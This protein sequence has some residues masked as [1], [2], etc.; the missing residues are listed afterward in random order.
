MSPA[1]LLHPLP[2]NNG[3]SSEVLVSPIGPRHFR[4]APWPFAEPNMTF[5][6]PARHVEGKAFPT[7][8][9]LEEAFVAARVEQLSVKLTNDGSSPGVP[10]AY[11]FGSPGQRNGTRVLFR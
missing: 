7:S 11:A 2:L 4:L 9:A 10:H 1:H 6:F 5:A 8:E 3:D